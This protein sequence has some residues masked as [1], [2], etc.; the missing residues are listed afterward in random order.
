MEK[1]NLQIALENNGYETSSYNGDLCIR[2]LNSWSLFDLG[3][4]I[5]DLDCKYHVKAQ[6]SKPKDDKVMVWWTHVKYVEE[7]QKSKLQ[8]CL[9]ST[10]GYEVRPND[11]CEDYPDNCIVVKLDNLNELFYLGTRLN[12]IL[13][14][15]VISDN[16]IETEFVTEDDK[17]TEV[18]VYFVNVQY[19]E[20]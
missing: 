17:V 5:S 9:E 15:E 20:S 10:F 2:N 16:K 6:V 19:V 8:L 11:I 14:Y 3:Y 12:S 1:S 4:N 13:S 18:Y 7:P